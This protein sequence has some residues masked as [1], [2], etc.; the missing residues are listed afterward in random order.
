MDIASRGSTLVNCKDWSAV[1]G[2][3]VGSESVDSALVFNPLC[4]VIFR[5]AGFI[6]L[7]SLLHAETRSDVLC[8]RGFRERDTRGGLRKRND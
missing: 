7:V 6:N 2:S 3:D 4:I 1:A 5:L 8:S